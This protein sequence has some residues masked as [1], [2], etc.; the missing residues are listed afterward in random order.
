MP[1]NVR[2]FWITLNID[3][4]ETQIATGPVRKDGGFNLSVKMRDEGEILTALHV[5]GQAT[6]DGALI[7]RCKAGASAPIQ[8]IQDDMT[9]ALEGFS[10]QTDR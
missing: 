3:G 10:I 6:K 4:R 5:T 2:N 8:E 9:G 7:L 1:R